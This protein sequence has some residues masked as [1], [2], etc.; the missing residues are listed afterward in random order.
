MNGNE[1]LWP[2]GTPRGG[3]DIS[4]AAEDLELTRLC[5][6]LFPGFQGGEALQFASPY[7]TDDPETIRLRQKTISD[8]LRYPELLDAFKRLRGMLD[9]LE[10]CDKGVQDNA[11]GLRVTRMDAAMD[12]VKK[13]V[14]K[15]EKNL[16]KQ[17]ADI[18]EE[19]ASDNRYA[20]LLRLT[21]F[22]R[23]LTAL[24]VEAVTLLRDSLK[25]VSTESP[26]LA[27]L[28]KWASQC[29]E[30]DKVADTAAVLRKLDEEW[31]GVGAFSVDVCLDG[32]R[33]VVGLEMA[34]VRETPFAQ[35][36]MLEGAGSDSPHEGITS[37]L[38]FPQNGSAVLFQEYLLSEVGY[39]VRGK[40]TRLREA[41]I[42]LP[43]TGGTE[44]LTLKDALRFYTGAAAFACRLRERGSALCAPR[45]LSSGT[46]EFT[47]ARLPEQTCTGSLPVPNDLYLESGG[48]I[49]MTGPNSSGKTCCL[50]MAGQFLFLGQLGCLLPAEEAAFAPRDKLL[51][52]FAAGESETGEDSRMGLEVQRLRLLRERMTKKS[53][54][55]LNE[56]MTSTSAEEGG[57]ICVDLL[58]DLAQKGVP[59]ILVTHFNH[60]WPDL[61]AKF[62]A[63]GCAERLH[64]LVMTV[65]ETPD[66]VEYLYRLKDAPPPPSSHARAVIAEKGVTLENMLRILGEKGVDMRP[67]SGAWTKLRNGTLWEVK[68]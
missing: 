9:E 25:G 5:A 15:L 42:K 46:L 27:M 60:I 39:E 48:S 52:L 38:S 28:G 62:A 44:L 43:V 50:I 19:S 2:G 63:L 49:L 55:L 13:A 4:L 40:L 66:G 68:A 51:T 67:D 7:L 47:A 12:G 6:L 21:H 54:F 65:D 23:R 11:M 1:L 30:T 61:Q 29:C 31:K 59:G 57:Q 16:S 22:R 45:L 8:L 24:Y 14:M 37:L 33:M 64:S 18:L 35:P 20:Q 36:G 41:L 53:I 17:G 32:R 34:E 10:I 58:A 26:A 3:L 56:P